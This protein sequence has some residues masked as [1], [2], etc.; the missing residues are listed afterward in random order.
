MKSKKKKKYNNNNQTRKYKNY[1]IKVL[2]LNKKNKKK[3]RRRRK[4]NITKTKKIRGSN[5]NL[6][7]N[8]RGIWD[9]DAYMINVVDEEPAIIDI[10]GMD[11][12]ERHKQRLEEFNNNFLRTGIIEW[13]REVKGKSTKEPGWEFIYGSVPDEDNYVKYLLDEMPENITSVKH[14]EWYRADAV[15][16]GNEASSILGEL[17]NETGKNYWID[18]RL[19]GKRW[20]GL[21]DKT[22]ADD[23]IIE[24]EF[25]Y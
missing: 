1:R 12:T 10:D 18:P 14:D 16:L 24:I 17:K 8:A 11:E 6:R 15:N 3:S 21:F 4:K 13:K 22:S 19:F 9:Y 2:Q 7:K 5:I 20:K 25:P 23:K